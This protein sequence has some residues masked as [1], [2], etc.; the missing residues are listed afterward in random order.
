MSG[1]AVFGGTFNPIHNGH[2][3]ILREVSKLNF[4]EKILV[5]PDNIP[6]HKQTNFLADNK[7]RIAMCEIAIKGIDK[8]VLDCRE[9]KRG[10][11]SYTYH[12][13]LELK[14]EYK[15]NDIYFV[16]GGDMIM[17]L[18]MWYNSEELFKLTKFIA[19]SRSGI[20]KKRFD[21]KLAF[22]KSIGADIYFID[23]DIISVSSTKIREE[24][25]LN[26]NCSVP[27]NVYNY[28]ME[29]KVYY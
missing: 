24:L 8:A 22:L 10:G 26:K 13:V 19:F 14:N 3:Q 21:D 15:N 5:M 4:V 27:E 1:I 25:T 7:H 29:N 6:P 17:S 9:M 20:D 12:T 11:K 23:C 28:I 18:D 2:I 16:C